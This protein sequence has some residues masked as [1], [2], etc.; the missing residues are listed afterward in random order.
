MPCVG[1]T[2][3]KKHWARRFAEGR[4]VRR[5]KRGWRIGKRQRR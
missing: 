4:P 2:Y 5:V 1:R 3:K